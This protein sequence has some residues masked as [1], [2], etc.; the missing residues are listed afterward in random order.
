[1]NAESA[2]TI[3][4]SLADGCDPETGQTLGRDHVLQKPDVIRALAIAVTALEHH[5]RGGSREHGPRRARTGLPWSAEEDR[6]L[7]AAHDADTPIP[8]IADTH[9]RTAG[10]IQSRLVK[11]GRFDSQTQGS[12]RPAAADR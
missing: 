12:A 4:S 7:L 6:Q 2:L 11:L 9:E 1:M 5:A 10:A 3:I 8:T